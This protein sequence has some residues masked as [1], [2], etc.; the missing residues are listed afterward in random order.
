MYLSGA[1]LGLSFFKYI[2]ITP[3]S[4]GIFSYIDY[5]AQSNKKYIYYVF[6]E[7]D[8]AVGA[9]MTSS[10]IAP[11]FYT[12]SLVDVDG[13]SD[14]YQFDL[15][16]QSGDYQNTEDFFEYNTYGKYNTYAIGQKQ[17]Y[18]LTISALANSDSL[19]QSELGLE[20]SV[21]YLESLRNFIQNGKDKYFKDKA[22]NVFYGITHNF[23]MKVYNDGVNIGNS[24][25]FLITFDFIQ[26]Q[27]INNSIIE[28]F[29]Y[30]IVNKN[31]NNKVDTSNNKTRILDGSHNLDGSENLL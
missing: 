27:D 31:S 30:N 8:I 15:G 6:P 4:T 14:T 26:T 13:T 1:Y 19:H 7:T 21:E 18:K 20:Q 17:F 16:I 12:D 5:S 2:P 3:Y 9:G 25:P 28:N 22:G 29:D 11:V 23:K 24:Q 10:E